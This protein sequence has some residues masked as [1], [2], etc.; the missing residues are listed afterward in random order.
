MGRRY[1][2]DVKSLALLTGLSGESERW[3]LFLFFFVV[4]RQEVFCWFGEWSLSLGLFARESSL[5]V[6]RTRPFQNHV[7]VSFTS[8]PTHRC[9]NLECC[10][11]HIQYNGYMKF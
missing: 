8:F 7:A 9:L 2:V 5:R 1:H 10:F 4:D 6:A 11:F 3:N